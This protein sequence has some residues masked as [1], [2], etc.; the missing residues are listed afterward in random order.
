MNV[1]YMNG[2]L[3]RNLVYISLFVPYKI[4]C[5]STYLCTIRSMYNTTQYLLSRNRNYNKNSMV[6]YPKKTMD[7]IK[8]FSAN[9]YVLLKKCNLNPMMID[10]VVQHKAKKA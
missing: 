2:H 6:L 5:I 8:H 1:Q 7:N 9:K 3:T 4:L 10:E